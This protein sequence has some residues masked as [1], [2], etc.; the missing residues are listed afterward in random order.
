MDEKFQKLIE[1][2]AAKLGTT[3]EH[4]WGVLVRQAPISG[5]VDLV[6]CV[7]IA[8]VTVWWVAL[9]KRKTTCPPETETNRY[10]KAEWRDEGALLAW[11][12]TVIFGV[13]AL[14]SA[15]VSAQGIVAAFANPEYWALKQL[16]K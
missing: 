6:L 16:V 15:I 14:I 5:A 2:L 7:V 13:L 4:L 8:A 3:A 12:V 1:A 11:I 10:P 9:V